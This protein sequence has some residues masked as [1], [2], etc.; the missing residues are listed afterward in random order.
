MTFRKK[1]K[2][3][4]YGSCP[5]FAGAFPYFGTRIYFPKGS[6]SFHAACEQGIFE[7]ENVRVLQSFARPD[8]VMFDVGANIGLMA[9]PILQKE[10]KCR[11]VSFE[12]SLNVLP[13][14]QR[15]I[16]ENPHGDRWTLIPKAV[17]AKSGCV[18]FSLS[19]QANSLFDGIRPTQRVATVRQV[20]V[21]L[22]TLDETW[23]GMGS[24]PV[25]HIK[26]DVEGAE[27]DVLRGAI[28]CLRKERPPI[29]LEWNPVNLAAYGC[30][31]SSLLNFA[32]EENYKLYAVPQLVEIHSA[33]E[34]DLHML[35]T[36][37]FLL[38]PV[39][40]NTATL[41]KS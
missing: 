16:K 25:S 26:I 34:L 4:L 32:A 39:G 19:E 36:E 31:S 3:W 21:E 28:G 8:A 7:A 38:M 14:L 10:E 6:W 33:M 22:T 23:H 12:P 15:T 2:K 11:I 37:S 9:A 41:P 20:E 1:I 30:P 27:L 40:M 18:T 17:G 35:F 24:P 29:L 13:F 5:G